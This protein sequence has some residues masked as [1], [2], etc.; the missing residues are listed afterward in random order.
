MDVSNDVDNKGVAEAEGQGQATITASLDDGNGII[1]GAATA[2]V[3]GDCGAPGNPD[4][5]RIV[6][7]SSTLSIGVR[8]QLEIVAIYGNCERTVT[9]DKDS[10]FESL[11]P[12]IVAVDRDLGTT[13]GLDVGAGTVQARFKGNTATASVNVIAEEVVDIDLDQTGLIVRS[14]ADGAF[15][16]SC[17][18]DILVNNSL[19]TEVPVSGLATWVVRNER[20]LLEQPGTPATR[21]F[22]PLE[23]GQSVVSCYYGGRRASVAIVLTP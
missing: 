16:L 7:G 23:I 11:A 8:A 6:P 9:R 10:R 22:T 5:I 21:T 17:S 15:S 19:E 13:F 1:Q 4:S 14:V 20:V 18:A 2:T 3:S 12:N